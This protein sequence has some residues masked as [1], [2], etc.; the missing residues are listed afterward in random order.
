MSVVRI[1]AVVLQDQ[2]RE[3]VFTPTC[4]GLTTAFIRLVNSIAEVPIEKKKENAR[5]ERGE[6]LREETWDSVSVY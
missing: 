3:T 4:R 6:K 2:H 1:E 5:G